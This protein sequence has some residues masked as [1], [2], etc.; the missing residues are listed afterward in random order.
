MR[1]FSALALYRTD[2][3]L[4][5]SG[6]QSYIRIGYALNFIELD[7]RSRQ[8]HLIEY[9]LQHIY[10]LVVDVHRALSEVAVGLVVV[11]AL[12]AV[13]QAVHGSIQPTWGELGDLVAVH[14]YES[15]EGQS[16]EIRALPF[17]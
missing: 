4:G 16:Q 14:I 11:E 10:E 3:K 2:A 5:E 1:K 15:M 9:H 7:Q 17:R 6:R 12:H 8:P 13:C